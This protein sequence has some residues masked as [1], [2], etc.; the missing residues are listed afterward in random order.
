MPAMPGLPVK[1]HSCWFGR[2][3][4]ACKD[5]GRNPV[6]DARGRRRPAC[7]AS[8]PCRLRPRWRRRCAVAARRPSRGLRWLAERTWCRAGSAAIAAGPVCGQSGRR[9]DRV[10]HL[11]EQR[12]RWRQSRLFRRQSRPPRSNGSLHQTIPQH[13]APT[14]NSAGIGVISFRKIPGYSRVSVGLSGAM[15]LIAVLLAAGCSGGNTTSS[16]GPTEFAGVYA[17]TST[18]NGVSRPLRVTVSEDGFVFMQSIGGVVCPGD[19][20]ESSGLEGRVFSS[21]TTEQCIVGGFPCPVN[22]SVSGSI[23][24][25]T[26]TGSGQVLLGCPNGP[27]QPVG[28]T[29]IALLQ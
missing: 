27:T 14:G 16:G 26:V 13:S 3:L 17:G 12:L 4:T 29:F 22:T 21:T 7:G 28:F 6:V 11:P 5:S 10:D 25:S 24:G 15:L 1:H 9:A 23:E 18:A 20:P 2:V 19:L 8:R